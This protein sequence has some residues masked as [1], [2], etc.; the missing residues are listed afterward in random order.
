MTDIYRSTVTGDETTQ[1]VKTILTTEEMLLK[2]AVDARLFLIAQAATAELELGALRKNC[3]HH[4]FTDVA[5]FPYDTR[6]CA[7]CGVSMGSV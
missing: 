4:A 5:G 7:V 3:K 1:P 2:T 6:Y